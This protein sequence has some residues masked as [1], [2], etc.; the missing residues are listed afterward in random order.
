[1]K[2]KSTRVVREFDGIMPDGAKSHIKIYLGDPY[3][4]GKSFRCPLAIEGI[5]FEHQYP[6]IGGSDPLQSM[7]LAISLA[8]K[9]IE[10]F[11]EQGG[12]LF[13]RGTQTKYEMEYW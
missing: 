5:H 11:V 8:K 10:D 4:F 13:Y 7:T 3:S 9:M 1:M 6:D 12:L 2:T